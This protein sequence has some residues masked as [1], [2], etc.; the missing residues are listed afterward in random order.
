GEEVGMNHTLRQVAR[1]VFLEM[2]KLR[3]NLGS[4]PAGNLISPHARAFE[5][6]A[7]ILNAKTIRALERKIASCQMQSGKGCAELRAMFGLRATDPNAI[8]K[9][10]NR[11]GPA[12]QPAQH[13]ARLGAQRRGAGKAL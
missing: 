3:F 1:P 8:E 7:P 13:F 2:H 5:Q 11:G 9:T 4:E 12:R 6:G 10:H